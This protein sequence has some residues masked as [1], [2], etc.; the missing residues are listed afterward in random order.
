MFTYDRRQD[1]TSKLYSYKDR[2]TVS[3]SFVT[4]ATVTL[5]D[6]VKLYHWW[7]LSSNLAALKDEKL[8]ILQ[9]FHVT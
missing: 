8:T 3:F 1:E 7:S 4:A 5:P 2:Q 9:H 6:L